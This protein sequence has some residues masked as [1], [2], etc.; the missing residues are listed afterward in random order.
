MFYQE[1]N[2]V[3]RNFFECIQYTDFYYIPHLHRHLEFIL[4]EQGIVTVESEEHVQ[5]VHAGECALILSNR[6]HAYRSVAGTVVKVCIFSEDLVP[7]FARKT[8]GKSAGGLKFTCCPEVLQL[9]RTQLAVTDRRPDI[10]MLKAGLY[11]LLHEY[12]AQVP[13]CASTYGD[14]ALIHTVLRYINQHYRENITLAQIADWAG[15]ERH[16]LSRYFHSH[17]S[18]N[19]KSLVNWY[20]VESAIELLEHT[21]LSM[22]EI[23]LESGFQSVRSFNRI[24]LEFT[25][26]TPCQ[27]GCRLRKENGANRVL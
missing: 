12:C 7:A 25:Q 21:D 27:F 11:A 2:S 9:V 24:F 10:L 14:P 20:R 23:A 15:Y 3:G 4:V 5:Q 16:Y 6:T 17:I 13:L 22:T 8:E 1:R 18:M 26:S 19:F